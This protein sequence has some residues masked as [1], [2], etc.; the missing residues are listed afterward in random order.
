MNLKVWNGTFQEDVHKYFRADGKELS[1]VT[2]MLKRMLFAD[3]YK[4]VSQETL[5]NA[6]DRGHLVH[7]RIELYDNMGVGTDMPEVAAY[8]RLKDEYGLEFVASEFLVSD[9]ENF[10]SAIDKV[11]HAKGAPEDEV[12]LADI[13]TTY[14]FNRDYVSWQ[15]SVYAYFFGLLNPDIKVT[16]AFGIWLRDDKRRGLIAKVI[17]VELKPV[18][19]VRELIRCAVS[20]EAFTIERMPSYIAENVDKLVYLTETIKALTEEKDG[21][22]ADILKHMQEDK[23]DKVDTGVMLFTRKAGAT[24]TT[25]DSKLFKEEHADLFAQYSKTSTGQ[26]TLQL[27]L[28]E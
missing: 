7:S 19:I 24:R 16:G 9:D 6:A 20:G 2:G 25:F 28:R 11:Y 8:A 15:L 23:C 22:V 18:E 12:V 1:G 17:P 27:K 10:A 5:A 13:K 26:E 3:E 21:I 4:G 14:A